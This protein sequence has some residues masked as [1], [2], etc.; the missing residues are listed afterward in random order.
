MTYVFDASPLIVLATAERLELLTH[1]ETCLLTERVQ[2]EV[3]EAGREHSYPDAQRIVRAIES[4]TLAVRAGDETDRFES[5]ASIE[6][7]S[8]AD[9]S[10]LALA[11]ELGATAVMDEAIGR[12]VADAEGIETRGTAFIVLSLVRDG[13]LSVEA[14]RDAVDDLVAAGWYC[15]TDLYRRIQRKLDDLDEDD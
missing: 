10:T 11:G 14:G 6:G 13:P 7:L 4:G 12:D 15:S 3:V 8:A 2:A 5:L 1:F 9:A